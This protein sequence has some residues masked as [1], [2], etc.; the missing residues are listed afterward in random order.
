MKRILAT[1]LCL[2]MLVGMFAGCGEKKAATKGDGSTVTIGLCTSSLIEDYD[3]NA[4][5]K[6]LEETTGYNIEFTYF[7]SSAN[8]AKA[9]ISTMMAG[10]EKLPDIIWGVSLGSDVY[11]EYGEDGYFIDLAQFF[12]DEEK[13]KPFWDRF[14][15]ELSEA[16]QDSYL[17]QLKN[18]ITG[19]IYAF[20]TMQTSDIDIMDYTLYIN[21]KWLDKAGMS[22]PTSLDELYKVLKYFKENDMNGNGSKEDEI[23]MIGSVGSLGGDVVNYIINQFCYINDQK[24]FNLENGKLTMPFTSN[25]YREGLKYANKLVSE[26]LLSSM[27]L[28]LSGQELRSIIMPAE[29]NDELVG[30][31]AGHLTLVAEEDNKAMYDYIPMNYWNRAVLNQN[32]HSFT[33]YIT[34]DCENPDAAWDILMTLF[35]K[36]GSLRLR[37][38][39]KGVDWTEADEGTKSY[40]GRDAEI[41]VINYVFG[42]QNNSLWGRVDSTLLI[43]AENEVTQVE[44]ATEWITYR[45]Q[46]FGEVHDKFMAAAEKYNP[47]ETCPTLVYTTEEKE[48]YD[49]TISNCK[50]YITTSR[51]SFVTGSMNP[52]SDSE[53]N[54]YIKQLD[55]LGLNDWMSLAQT[56]YERQLTK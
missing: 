54:A 18:P 3:N 4:L 42:N 26:G 39:E 48:Q 32:L 33:T 31:F 12:N 40:I 46:I 35:S 47:K 53:W 43:D 41:K 7:S 8:D 22:N 45:N 34:E 9:Q 44:G 56:A 6:W 17:R 2:T 51:S 1:F 28:T 38:G 50:N 10:G 52:N 13:S 27:S 25:E 23:P 30:V 16:D 49:M 21:Q 20:P 24:Y 19:A 55:T 29:G 36:E 11:T 15:N 14:N 37:Y 5:T